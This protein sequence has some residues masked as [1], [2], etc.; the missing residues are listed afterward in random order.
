MSRMSTSRRRLGEPQLE[1]RQEAVAARQDLRLAFPLGQDPQRVVETGRSDVVELTRDHPSSS[2]SGDGDAELVAEAA[3]AFAGRRLM[4]DTPGAD[5]GFQAR[6]RG[7]GAAL[8]GRRPSIGP[9]HARVNENVAISSRA[10]PGD[11]ST[12]PIRSGARRERSSGRRPRPPARGRARPRRRSAGPPSA[13]QSWRRTKPWISSGVSKPRVSRMTVDHAWLAP[14]RLQELDELVEGRQADAFLAVDRRPERVGQ[15]RRLALHEHRDAAP[16]RP[17]PPSR[18][19]TA[20]SPR[21]RSRG[22]R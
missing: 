5:Q 2:A 19:G 21:C 1:Q 12:M 15:R 22:G 9:P 16:A 8:R 7:P 11:Q 20:R 17:P 13:S 4:C 10:G 6:P 18:R 14:A 3:G